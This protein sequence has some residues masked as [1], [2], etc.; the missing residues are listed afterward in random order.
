MYNEIHDSTNAIRSE[1]DAYLIGNNIYNI[2]KDPAAGYG[3][4]AVITWPAHDLHIVDN[5]IHNVDRGIEHCGGGTG[6][7]VY[8]HNNIISLSSSGEFH[9]DLTGAVSANSLVSNN[10]FYSSSG[11]AIINWNGVDTQWDIMQFRQFTSQGDY[12]V[13]AATALFDPANDVL[14]MPDGSPVFDDAVVSYIYQMFSNLY[15][16]DV[17]DDSSSN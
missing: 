12:C 5:T 16:I 10:V 13:E 17:S 7:A 14:Y 8:V 6:K 2:H 15:G 1:G 11:K 4:N 9:I 3:G